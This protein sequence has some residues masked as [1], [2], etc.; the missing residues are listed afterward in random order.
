MR[1]EIVKEFHFEAAHHLP[2]VGPNHKCSR[3]HGHHFRVE[4]AVEGEVDPVMGW[5]MD[6]GDLARV[7]R[8][9]VAA[10]DHQ[11]LN[12][13]PELRN[14][15]SENLAH[16]LFRQFSARV[17]GVCAVTVHESPTSRCTYRPDHREA[18]RESETRVTVDGFVWSAAHFLLV[19]PGGREPIHG[20]DYRVMASGTVPAG[21]TE[22]ARAAI[23]EEV[24]RLLEALD[25]RLLVPG[26]PAIGTLQAEGE[27]LILAIPGSPRLVLPRTDCAVVPVGNTS[28]ELL[29]GLLAQDLAA[30][31]RIRA[32]DIRR[33]EVTV[34]E[35]LDAL[36]RVEALVRG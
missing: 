36:A 14:P 31:P 35:G 12:R 11:D 2:E 18:P 29:A 4:V 19:P 24:S 33:I 23:R 9:V 28:T 6:F 5:V 27:S 26:D 15:T 21:R 10:L 30:S 16:L 22:E 34:R 7:A 13:L 3:L 1:A 17:P 25:H 32:M 8:E 20:H